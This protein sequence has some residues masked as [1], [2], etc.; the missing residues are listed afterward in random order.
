MKFDDEILEKK[1]YQNS[2]SLDFRIQ[3]A[4]RVNGIESNKRFQEKE[5]RR[6][7]SYLK[8]E[9]LEEGI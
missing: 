9:R 8:R 5:K 3:E 4:S 6:S 1:V 2:F 7:C